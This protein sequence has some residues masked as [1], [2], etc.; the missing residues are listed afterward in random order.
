MDALNSLL[1]F[2]FPWRISHAVI[3]ITLTVQRSVFSISDRFRCQYPT[4]WLDM[5]DVE[6]HGKN[7]PGPAYYNLQHLRN[8]AKRIIEFY[9]NR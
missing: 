1:N 7:F 8:M 2:Y 9:Y 5:F 4:S 3:I 6:Y